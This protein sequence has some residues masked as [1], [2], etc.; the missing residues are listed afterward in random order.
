MTADEG[1]DIETRIV[2]RDRWMRVREDAIRRRGGSTGVY[3]V[4]EPDF[5]VIVP[6]ED[7][8]QLHLVQQFRCPVHGRPAH[9]G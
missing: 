5:V 4:V 8:G 3:G 2:Y 9:N 6:F 1:E 7:D